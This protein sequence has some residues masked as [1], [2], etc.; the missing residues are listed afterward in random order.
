[1]AK[2]IIIDYLYKI[3]IVASKYKFDLYLNVQNK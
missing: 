1:M 3:Y 2:Y